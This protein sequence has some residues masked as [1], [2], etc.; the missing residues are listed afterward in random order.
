[1]VELV[2]VVVATGTRCCVG[3]WLQNE[4][5]SLGNSQ[6]VKGVL[7]APARQA[8]LAGLWFMM[9]MIMLSCAGCAVLCCAD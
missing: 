8:K 5:S 2:G 1:M 6:Y 4:S 3:W 7:L 9:I